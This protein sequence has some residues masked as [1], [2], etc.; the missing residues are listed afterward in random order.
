M[1]DKELEARFSKIDGKLD[2]INSILESQQHALKAQHDVIIRLFGISEKQGKVVSD[3]FSVSQ[4]FLSRITGI[5]EK[6]KEIKITLDFVGETAAD[7]GARIDRAQK[8]ITEQLNEF[9]RLK[10]DFQ[11]LESKAVH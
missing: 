3:C 11:D 10:G 6:L 5:E 8:A 9:Q 4:W 2:A 7:N 1:T